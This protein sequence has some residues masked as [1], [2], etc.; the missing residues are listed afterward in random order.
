MSADHTAALL[1]LEFDAAAEPFQGD[2]EQAAATAA[3]FEQRAALLVDKREQL[4]DELQL[5]GQYQEVVEHLAGAAQGLDNSPRLAVIPFLVER[6]EDLA[7][8]AG[9][10]EAAL[11]AALEAGAKAGGDEQLP[12]MLDDALA[13]LEADLVYL[14][15]GGVFSKEL[16]GRWLQVKRDEINALRARPHPYEFCLY[17]DV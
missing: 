3:S 11:L 14:L 6:R 7:A 12:R 15:S 17:F 9:H 5:I 16:I 10:A 4:R 1:K 2:L 13:A 8:S